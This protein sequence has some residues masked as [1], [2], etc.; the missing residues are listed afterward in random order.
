MNWLGKFVCVGVLMQSFQFL[1]RMYF[2][3]VRRFAEIKERNLKK[4]KFHMFTAIPEK[5]LQDCK[6]YQDSKRH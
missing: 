2:I 4:L 3:V 5:D 6:F 1:H